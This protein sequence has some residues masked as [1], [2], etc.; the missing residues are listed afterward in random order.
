MTREEVIDHLNFMIDIY[1]K[2][3]PEG[4]DYIDEWWKGHEDTLT[5]FRMSIDALEFAKWVTDEIFRGTVEEDPELFAELACRRLW[6]LGIVKAKGCVEWQIVGTPLD[7]MIKKLE[8]EGE[9]ND[10]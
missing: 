5:S 3:P 4:C 1:P 7:D 6:K 8:S 2:E 10:N 9:N